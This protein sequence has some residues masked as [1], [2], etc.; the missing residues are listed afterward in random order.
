MRIHRTLRISFSIL[1]MSLAVWAWGTQTAKAA[2]SVTSFR[3]V[4]PEEL[5]M[6]S[7]PAAPGAAAIISSCTA[8]SSAMT[9][10]TPVTK[11]ITFESKS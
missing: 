10:P 5:Q 6:T 8:R 2:N 4:S 11:I 9:T 3:P 1:I 7:E